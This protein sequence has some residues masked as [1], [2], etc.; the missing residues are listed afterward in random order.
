AGRRHRGV[1]GDRDRPHRAVLGDRREVDLDEGLTVLDGTVAEEP[2]HRLLDTLVQPEHLG[3]RGR[4]RAHH[5]PSR[6]DDTESAEHAQCRPPG[7]LAIVTHAPLSLSPRLAKTPRKYYA[8]EDRPQQLL[9][10]LR[11]RPA[12][13]RTHPV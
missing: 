12:G 4:R 8:P 5:E 10:A 9:A 3:A 6:S 13:R 2:F 1:H 11:R 7:H